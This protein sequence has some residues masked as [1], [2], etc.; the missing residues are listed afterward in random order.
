MLHSGKTVIQHIYDSHY[1]GADEAADLRGNGNRSSTSVDDERYAEV[2]ARLEYQAGTR[3]R[4]AGR[5][6]QLVLSDL[7]NS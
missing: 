7:R 4:L 6:L 3:H 5:H 2:L 1:E